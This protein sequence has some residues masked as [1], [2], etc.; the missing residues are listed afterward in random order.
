M[1][2]GGE[3]TNLPLR[4]GYRLSSCEAKKSEL[5]FFLKFS[6][7]LLLFFES[8]IVE[9]FPLLLEARSKGSLVERILVV[10]TLIAIS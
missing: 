3:L 1:R 8:G 9:I 2:S 5:N 10:R 4:L 7:I 6:R